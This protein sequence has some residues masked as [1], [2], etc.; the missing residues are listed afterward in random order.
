MDF[1]PRACWLARHHLLD[2]DIK[3]LKILHTVQTLAE[4]EL[5]QATA[6]G[7]SSTQQEIATERAVSAAVEV[8]KP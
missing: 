1:Q 8:P 6:W 5:A 7:S 2:I 3:N 4:Q